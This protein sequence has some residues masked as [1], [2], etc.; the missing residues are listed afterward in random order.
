MHAMRP[1]MREM[2][3]RPLPTSFFV[4]F[5]CA[6][7][8][9][10]THCTACSHSNSH[11]PLR[12]PRSPSPAASAPRT[13]PSRR[14]C[15]TARPPTWRGHSG[16]VIRSTRTSLPATPLTQFFLLKMVK[17]TSK[18]GHLSAEAPRE[19]FALE[20]AHFQNPKDPWNQNKTIQTLYDSK[21]L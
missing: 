12:C 16:V 15:L 6:L 4:R 14:C 19:R 18:T 8:A 3:V 7:L 10:S 5:D 2:A 20:M 9:A 1:Q 13:R 21:S 11:S 17:I